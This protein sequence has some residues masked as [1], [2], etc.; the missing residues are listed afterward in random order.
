[1][2]SRAESVGYSGDRAKQLDALLDQLDALPV[3]NPPAK[4]EPHFNNGAGRVIV[5]VWCRAAHDKSSLK[6]PYV[7]LNKKPL[8]D[9]SAVPTWLVAT[10]RLI[11]KINNEHA[12]CL[13]AAEQAKAASTKRQ[14]GLCASS[15]AHEYPFL[16][17]PACPLRSC[18]CILAYLSILAILL[19]GAR[20]RMPICRAL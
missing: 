19:R 10:E 4:V 9:L 3:V 1:M 8:D 11:N 14:H 20:S 12:S 5:N 18:C 6:Q 15:N 2:A 16:S 7:S 17:P 13:A